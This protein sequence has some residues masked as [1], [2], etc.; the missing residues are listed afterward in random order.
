[1]GQT[2]SQEELEHLLPKINV[3]AVVSKNMPSAKL[4]FNKSSLFNCKSQLTQVN[5]YKGCKMIMC[6]CV[7]VCV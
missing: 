5:L 6:V 3:L 1:M 4:C 7:I 2:T